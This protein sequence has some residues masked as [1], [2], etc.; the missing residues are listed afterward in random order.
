[1]RFEADHTFQT[2]MVQYE[3]HDET[4]DI[5]FGGRMLRSGEGDDV[6]VDVDMT[7]GECDSGE[8]EPIDVAP[9]SSSERRLGQEEGKRLTDSLRY[10]MS[11]I[12]GLSTKKTR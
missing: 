2:D 1:M 10:M 11:K 5:H 4:R 9:T 12:H 8:E 6:E 7:E 3:G